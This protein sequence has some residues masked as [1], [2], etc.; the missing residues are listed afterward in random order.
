MN[1]AHIKRR[2]LIYSKKTHSCDT[3]I[4]LFSQGIF[5]VVLNTEFQSS[6]VEVPFW[7]Q[8]LLVQFIKLRLQQFFLINDSFGKMLTQT[9]T[10]L[11]RFV[12]FLQ[13]RFLIRNSAQFKHIT[14]LENNRPGFFTILGSFLLG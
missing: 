6:I 11:L 13:L 2:K 14:D 5:L 4:N 9:N 3:Q 8:S 12:N 7:F 10:A 1:V